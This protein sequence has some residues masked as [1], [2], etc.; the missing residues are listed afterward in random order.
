MVRRTYLKTL[1]RTFKANFVRLCVITGLTAISM[2]IVTGI[3]VLAPRIRNAV[4]LAVGVPPESLGYANFIADGV[5][6]ISF[7]F[8]VFFVIVAMLVVYMTVTRLIESERAQTGCFVTL[9]YSRGH[10]VFRYLC[11]VLAGVALGCVLGILLGFYVVSPILFDAIKEFFHLPAAANIFPYFGIGTSGIMLGFA[12]IITF[13]S[14]WR[15]ASVTPAA[16]MQGKSPVAGGRILFE[17][18]PFFWNRLPDKY[19][20]TMRNIFRYKVRFFLTVFSVLLGT[21]LVFCGL[22]LAFA[23]DKTDPTL[24]DTIRP[25]SAIIVVAAI[26]LNLLVVYNITNINIE[27]RKREIATLMVLGYRNFEITG[28]IFREIFVLTLLGVVIGVPAGYGIMY[29][30]F[31]YLK[32]GGIQYVDWYVWFITAGFALMS[33]AI[34]DLLL[35]RKIHKTDMNGALKIID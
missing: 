27:E 26:L 29:F 25:I 34:V 20:S 2:A 31:D 17:K 3:G 15:A 35:F 14:A 32:F 19:K 10:I 9:G 6:R 7:A 21:A 12:F 30:L 24:N 11:F 22:A 8:P 23:L 28:Y 16:I 18:M 1:T 13:W 33:L 5:E 4:D